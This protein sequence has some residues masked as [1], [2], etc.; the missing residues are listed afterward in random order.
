MREVHR[1]NS[2]QHK[3]F[4][5]KKAAMPGSENLISVTFLRDRLK[6]NRVD[7]FNGSFSCEVLITTRFNFNQIS[8]T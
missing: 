7:N 2:A 1:Q 5:I 4:K 8:I 6:L 3:K